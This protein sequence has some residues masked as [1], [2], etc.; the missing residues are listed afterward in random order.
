MIHQAGGMIHP[1]KWTIPP[2]YVVVPEQGTTETYD[3]SVV[4]VT[5]FW[6]VSVKLESRNS[7]S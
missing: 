4:T 6:L 7:V 1:K 2:D 3:D 5:N